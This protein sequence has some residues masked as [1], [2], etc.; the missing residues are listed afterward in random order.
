MGHKLLITISNQMYFTLHT[1]AEDTSLS[2][3]EIC[4]R[5]LDT[6]LGERGE[7]MH[8]ELTYK[9]GRRPGKRIP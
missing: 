5:S 8:I 7:K 1:L 9:G 4:R 3:A 2:I 6:T